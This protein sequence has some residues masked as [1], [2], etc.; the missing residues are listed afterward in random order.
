MRRYSVALPIAGHIFVE[1]EADDAKA[2]VEAALELQF[3]TKDIEEW[4]V[5][6]R[7]YTRGNVCY[8]PTPWEPEAELL[9][10]DDD[11]EEAP[12]P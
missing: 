6:E 11:D 5:M 2:A 8:C 1:V 4:Q 3:D 12:S 7:G 9:D 10:D